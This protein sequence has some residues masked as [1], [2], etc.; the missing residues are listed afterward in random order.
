MV[1]KGFSGDKLKDFDEHDEMASMSRRLVAAMFKQHRRRRM[2]GFR[3][4]LWGMVSVTNI[5]IDHKQI[6]WVAYKIRVAA[7]NAKDPNGDRCLRVLC[8]S[9]NL[10]R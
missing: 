7:E 4:A 1:M 10:K 8:M 6:P 9:A 3:N 5:S 2:Y